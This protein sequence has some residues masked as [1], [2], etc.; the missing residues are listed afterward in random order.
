L[1]DVATLGT[2]IERA[3]TNV[4]RSLIPQQLLSADTPFARPKDVQHDTYT[5]DTPSTPI[6]S[7][8]ATSASYMS[9]L[10]CLDNLSSPRPP[11]H[12]TA[13]HRRSGVGEVPGF[14]A[15]LATDV[16]SFQVIQKAVKVSILHRRAVGRQYDLFS[17]C[18]A[19]L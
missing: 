16:S 13:T 4:V 8:A 5:S 7:S 9:D 17:S 6:A 18:G 10:D 1:I 14:A 19:L 3:L 12:A 11:F 2:V 15:K